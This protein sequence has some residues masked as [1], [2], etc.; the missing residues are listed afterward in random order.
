MDEPFP[1]VMVKRT[2]SLPRGGNI[3]VLEPFVARLAEALAF[4]KT[5]GRLEMD[6]EAGAL[7]DKVYDE[8]V[9][10]GD[11]IPHTE[12]SAP[13]ASRVAMLYALAD[14][15]RVIRVEHLRGALAV[16]RLLPCIGKAD[17]QARQQ[18]PIPLCNCR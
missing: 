6:A 8:L 5:A 16:V 2:R 7:W 18:N 4:A 1:W 3:L 14:C 11:F 12:R 10:S 17:V 15:S 13:Y 9:E